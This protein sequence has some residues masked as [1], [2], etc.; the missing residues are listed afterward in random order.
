MCKKKVGNNSVTKRISL[1]TRI[2]QNYNQYKTPSETLKCATDL[3]ISV[4]DD[5]GGLSEIADLLEAAHDLGSADAAELVD[6]LDRCP[7]AVV[8]HAVAHQHVE[9]VLLVFDGQHHRHRLADLDDS[10]HFRSPWS[11]ADLIKVESIQL[12]I[13]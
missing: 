11:F 9:L 10:A 13:T 6:Q 2:S 12:L 5:G 7:D 1:N 8:G 4:G 3:E